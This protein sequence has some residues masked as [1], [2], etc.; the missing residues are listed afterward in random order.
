MCTQ[1]LAPGAHWMPGREEGWATTKTTLIF[2][3]SKWLTATC[4]HQEFVLHIQIPQ[5]VLQEFWPFYLFFFLNEWSIFNHCGCREKLPSLICTKIRGQI[6][7]IS[8]YYILKETFPFLRAWL[9]IFKYP[10]IVILCFLP[11]RA[12][13]KASC[14]KKKRVW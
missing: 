1:P 11:N 6:R 3:L 14:C 7:R 8:I 12:L 9:V 13:F 5:L 4:Y 2:M 10:R